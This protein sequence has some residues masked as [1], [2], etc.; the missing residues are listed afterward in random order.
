MV[1][2]QVTSRFAFH[3]EPLGSHKPVLVSTHIKKQK[4]KPFLVRSRLPFGSGLK[5][6]RFFRTKK[7]AADYV[8]HLHTVY[9]NRTIPN[10]P[11]TDGGCKQ[12]DEFLYRKNSKL[13]LFQ[14]VS[15]VYH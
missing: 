3:Q 11:A 9:T 10:P 13:T 8:S 6:R 2:F 14:E 4:A 1:C 5:Y 7:E 12:I 15:N